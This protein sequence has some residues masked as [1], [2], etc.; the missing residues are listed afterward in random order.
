MK[1][2]AKDLYLN[3]DPP[4][5]K[6]EK[7]QLKKSF[8]AIIKGEPDRKK[9][10]IN[11]SLNYPNFYDE[12]IKDMIAVGLYPSRSEAVRTAVRQFL[13]KEYEELDFLGYFKQRRLK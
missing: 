9:H 11:V 4:D 2:L 8:E 6:E 13:Y 5:I 3:E 10:L 7:E 12:C 1:T